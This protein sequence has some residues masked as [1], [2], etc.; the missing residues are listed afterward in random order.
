MGERYDPVP[1]ITRF[2]VGTPPVLGLVAVDEGVRLLGEA[3]IDRVRAKGMALTSMLVDLADEWLV[4]LGFSLASPREP[5][6]RGA[7]VSLAHPDASRIARA[8]IADAAVVPDFRAPDRLRLG[9]APLTTRFVD[10]FDGLDR[11]RRL[12]AEG[13]HER[14]A[15]DPGRVT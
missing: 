12:V 10:V 1:G 14:L 4:P 7:H 6:R 13:A 2:L 3:G 8:L 15:I 9:P 11:L 5:T